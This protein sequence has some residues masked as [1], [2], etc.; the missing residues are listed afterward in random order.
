M[1]RATVEVRNPHGLHARPA[2]LFVRAAGAYKLTTITVRN[3]TLDRPP[4]DAKSIISVLAA[5]VS[6]G[7][8]I[9]LSAE[10]V[11]EDGA[12]DGLVEFIELGAGEALEPQASD[13]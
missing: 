3:V 10:G 5:G 12:I 9:E 4:V 7:H 6:K 2:A 13:G 1:K 11:A 8:L